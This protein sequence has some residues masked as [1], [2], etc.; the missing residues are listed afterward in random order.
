[1]KPTI[2]AFLAVVFCGA[3]H[4]DASAAD[5][6]KEFIKSWA[7]AFDENDPAKIASF[8]DRSEET[9]LVLSAGLRIQGFKAIEK[10][11]Q[12]D[13]E[14]AKY[15]ESTPKKFAV[16]VLDDTALVTFEHQLK[17][18]LLSDDS[19]WQV[20]VRTTSVLHRVDDKW[21]IVLEHSSPING[22]ERVTPIDD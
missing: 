7:A 12:D 19:R 1:M 6:P 17:I 10:F 2:S 13:H 20:H 11:Y 22:I 3:I 5:P 18:R 14:S 4:G 8:Y 21:K 9:E 15:Y 16:R